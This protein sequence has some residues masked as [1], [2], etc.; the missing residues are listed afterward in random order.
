M[1][2]NPIPLEELDLSFNQ[3]KR[4]P[5]DV[6]H[7]LKKLK[8][9]KL[10]HN[11]FMDLSTTTAQALSEIQTLEKLDL[12]YTKLL[13]LPDHFFAELGQVHF[14]YFPIYSSKLTY[15]SY[16]KYLNC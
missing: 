1:I 6:F 12:S 5:K 15:Y 11:D 2:P 14:S 8:Y 9:L 16:R 7:H 10:S 4:L 13:R 3:I